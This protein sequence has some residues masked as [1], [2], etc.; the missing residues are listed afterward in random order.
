M[1]FERCAYSLNKLVYL[2]GV[3]VEMSYIYHS[4]WSKGRIWF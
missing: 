3:A 4:S 2:W 1:L